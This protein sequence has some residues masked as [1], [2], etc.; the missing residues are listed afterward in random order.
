MRSEERD[1]SSMITWQR[2]HT[3]VFHAYYT[4]KG[5]IPYGEHEAYYQGHE[6][7]G[8]SRPPAPLFV[9]LSLSTP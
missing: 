4:G 7:N 8:K 6:T 3:L 1:A 9:C 2:G 5:A